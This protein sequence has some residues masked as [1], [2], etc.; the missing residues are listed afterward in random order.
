MMIHQ[1]EWHEIRTSNDFC[2]AVN[3][4]NVTRDVVQ[5]QIVD[6]NHRHAVLGDLRQDPHPL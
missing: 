6:G 3:G 4:R 1:D 2:N 5:V